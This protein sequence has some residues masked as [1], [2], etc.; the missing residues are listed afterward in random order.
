MSFLQLVSHVNDIRI[1]FCYFSLCFLLPYVPN[2][3]FILLMNFENLSNIFAILFHV[4][5]VHDLMVFSVD[6][7][8]QHRFDRN[9]IRVRSSGGMIRRGGTAS[10]RSK[11][12]PFANLYTISSIWTGPGSNSGFLGAMPTTNHPS[13]STAKFLHARS[14]CLL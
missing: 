10:T 6:M 1:F 4:F 5:H 2:I 8:I 7:V 14:F 13:H 12:R 11:T 3:T 9:E